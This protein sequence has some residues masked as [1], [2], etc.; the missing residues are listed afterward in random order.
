MEFKFCKNIYAEVTFTAWSP[1]GHIQ[2]LQLDEAA[3]DQGDY[4]PPRSGREGASE[5][6][7]QREPSRQ[8]RLTMLRSAAML[9]G[10]QF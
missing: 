2:L 4:G 3:G 5:P 1:Q 10:L 8:S 7:E 9:P 6:Q